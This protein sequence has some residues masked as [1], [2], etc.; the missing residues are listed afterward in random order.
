MPSIVA[1]PQ[2]HARLHCDLQ[3]AGRMLPLPRN[4]YAARPPVAVGH[5]NN[6]FRS[7]NASCTCNV[8]EAGSSCLHNKSVCHFM[9][10]SPLAHS[11][12]GLVNAVVESVSAT[13]SVQVLLAKCSLLLSQLEFPVLQGHVL[14]RQ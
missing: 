13:C 6:A 3:L 1:V 10:L 14:A 9:R 8:A 7:R 11:W 2:R 12:V 5:R 4:G